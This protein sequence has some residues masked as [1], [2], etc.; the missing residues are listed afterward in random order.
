[1]EEKGHIV[2]PSLNSSGPYREQNIFKKISSCD[3]FIGLITKEEAESN[4]SLVEIEYA[5]SLKKKILILLQKG[6]RI[7]ESF[8]NKLS[9]HQYHHF[10]DNEDLVPL[11][12]KFLQE[13]D[14]SKQDLNS[15]KSN[16]K[17]NPLMPSILNTD[18]YTLDD[19]LGHEYYAYALTRFLINKETKAPLCISI[20]APW[21]AGKT[22]IMRMVRNILDKDSPYQNQNNKESWTVTLRSLS[23]TLKRAQPETRPRLT[24][25]KSSTQ[26]IV[27]HITIWFN[28]WKYQDS[29]QI[30]AG[31]ADSIINGIAERMK[32]VDREWFYLRLNLNRHDVN[33]IRSWIHERFYSYLWKKVL[34]WI[35]VMLIGVGASFLASFILE[36]QSLSLVGLTISGAFGLIGYLHNR[37][38]ILDASTVTT[39]DDFVRTPKYN[40]ELGFIHN[41]SKDLEIVF[42]TIPDKYR[43]RPI[44]IFIDD[45]DRCSPGKIAEVMEGI[46]LFL[47]GEFENCIFVMA[48][49]TEMIAASLETAHKDVLINLSQYHGNIPIGWKFMDKFIQLP[50]MIPSPSRDQMADYVTSLLS[51]G[52]MSYNKKGTKVDIRNSNDQKSLLQGSKPNPTP[53]DIMKAGDLIEMMSDTDEIFLEKVRETVLNF[54]VNP[55]EIKRYINSL[56]F[57]RF[58]LAHLGLDH[59]QDL[60]DQVSRWLFLTLKWPQITR[61]LYWSSVDTVNKKLEELEKIAQE[62]TDHAY[63]KK[64]TK[65]LFRVASADNRIHWFEDEQLMN[66]FKR[67]LDKYPDSP[68]SYGAGKGVY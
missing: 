9:K 4:N 10:G 20:Q 39:L 26:D 35:F 51:H 47:A 59:D 56:R 7:W 13:F 48:M 23:S 63:W 52:K 15:D 11:I 21:G 55:R 46:N 60:F 19:K 6:L 58:L 5:L 57:Y 1:L 22:S 65:I 67:E 66:F 45:L 32:L 49:D 3:A 25:L 30:W 36:D 37:K 44:I 2:I 33:S 64:H 43:S 68:I 54:S 8:W 14:K 62:S 40:K 16:S 28:A 17:M 34:P 29:N 18:K 53:P 31:L 12:D 41:V 27:P 42:N 24:D 50:M 61:W 38:E